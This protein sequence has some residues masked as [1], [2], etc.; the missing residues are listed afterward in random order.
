MTTIVVTVAGADPCGGAGIQAD[1]ETLAAL[2]AYG[3][4]V[5]AALTAQNTRGV[6][7]DWPLATADTR[8]VGHGRGPV[9]HAYRWCTP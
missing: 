8:K 5:I 7:G 4:A 6:Q 3:G 9:H 2:G 1:L